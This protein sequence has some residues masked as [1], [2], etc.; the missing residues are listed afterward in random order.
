MKPVITFIACA[1]NEKIYNRALVDSLLMQSDKRWKLIIYHNGINE[2]MRKWVARYKDPR[3]TYMESPVNT[4][5]GGSYNRI[6]ALN[7]VDTPYIIQTSIQ[8]YYLSWTVELIINR[9]R[10]E[11]NPDMCFWDSINHLSGYEVL[12]TRLELSYIDWGNFCWRTEI[13]KEV[14]IPKITEGAIPSDWY[15]IERG[16][17]LNLLKRLTK[18]ANVLTIHNI[19][20]LLIL[21]SDIIL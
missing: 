17:E 12:N 16:L 19:L 18:I 8:D 14:G 13:A 15:T 3:I 6:D 10:N 20:L 21:I 9:L 7:Y 2:K 1:F 11:N 4:G 5:C